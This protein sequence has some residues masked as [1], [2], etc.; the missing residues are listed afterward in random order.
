M[1]LLT[2]L[3]TTSVINLNTL[4]H[5]VNTGDTTQNPA[6]S[7][8]KTPLSDL[9]PLFTETQY[10]S[11]STGTNAI[12]VANSN[13]LASGINSLAEGYDTIASG[14]YSHAGGYNSSASGATSFIHSVNS[15]VIGARSAVIGGQSITGTTNDTVYVPNLNIN[16]APANDNTLTN[17]LVRA[18]NGTVKY[19]TLSGLA[20]FIWE[21]KTNIGGILY[22]AVANTGY[23]SNNGHPSNPSEYLL[24]TTAS[25][26]D[27]IKVNVLDGL[28][29]ITVSASQQFVY[30]TGNND[31]GGVFTSPFAFN[32]GKYESAEVTYL[33]F[34]KW[35]LSNFQTTE[36]TSGNPLTNRIY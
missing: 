10:W 6:G 14:I 13:S 18:T 27:I 1:A 9:V 21:T 35:I 3:N 32:F 4:I 5:I 26:G 17:V 33:G 34:N 19:K 8:Y 12:V 20:S 29:A 23:I 25:V 11:A 30:G 15:K 28:G 36:D 16:T 2:D 31:A 7:S 24:P 22:N